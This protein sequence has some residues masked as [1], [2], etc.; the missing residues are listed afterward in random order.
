MSLILER[1]YKRAVLV[2]DMN[3]ASCKTYRWIGC[4]ILK[5]VLR[6]QYGMAW[7]RLAGLRIGTGGGMNLRVS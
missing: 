4:I 1:R 5:W 7:T 2:G 6:K 3:E